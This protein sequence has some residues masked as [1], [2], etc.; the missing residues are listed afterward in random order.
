MEIVGYMW[1]EMGNR[2]NGKVFNEDING[3]MEK[4][5]VK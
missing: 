4:K 3:E 1:F 5:G 2:R